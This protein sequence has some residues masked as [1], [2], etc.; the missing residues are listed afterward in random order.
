M[1]NR[2]LRLKI[3]TILLLINAFLTVQKGIPPQR[4]AE[5]FPEFSFWIYLAYLLFFSTLLILIAALWLRIK[6]A[7]AVALIY[8]AS[9]LIYYFAAYPNYPTFFFILETI[10]LA[11]LLSLFKYF[12]S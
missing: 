12:F 3:L 5:A 7:Y 4:Q 8:V 1:A 6:I 2:P 11:I 9:C 10:Q